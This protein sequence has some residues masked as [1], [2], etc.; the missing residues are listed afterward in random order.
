MHKSPI[1]TQ[2]GREGIPE[3]ITS[4]FSSS[5]PYRTAPVQFED[6]PPVPREISNQTS[7][8]VSAR[9]GDVADLLHGREDVTG[10][11]HSDAMRWA[12]AMTEKVMV[13]AGI[14]GKTEESTT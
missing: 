3:F 13:V 6:L 1:I 10:S 14:D 11:S 12:L 5:G 7:P 8:E 9:S 4:G 2:I